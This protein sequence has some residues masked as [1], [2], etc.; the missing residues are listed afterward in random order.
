MVWP[1]LNNISAWCLSTIVALCFLVCGVSKGQ[2]IHENTE[3]KISA[4]GSQSEELRLTVANNMLL[5]QRNMGGWPKHVNNVKLDYTRILTVAEVAGIQND[6][7]RN[8]ATIDNGSTVK[9][10]RFLA[11]QYKLTGNKV[12]LQAVEKG[13]NYL[14]KA[15]YAN[16][17]WP[18]YYPDLSLYRHQITYNDHAMVNVLNLLY[19]VNTKCNDLESVD[20]SFIS[21]TKK[22][23]IKGIDCILKTQ[24]KVNGKLTVWCA[25]HD[26]KTLK[27]ANART[28]ELASLS[29]MESVGILYF[30]IRQKNPSE[31]IERAV[32][33]GASW[34]D[35][36]KIGG[37]KYTNINDPKQPNGWDRALVP[38]ND[39]NVWAR[40]Y[41]VETFEPFFCGRDGIKK[42]VL[43]QIEHERRMGYAWYGT[44][45]ERFLKLDYP[46]WLKSNNVKVNY[47]RS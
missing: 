6:A 43:N 19:D 12:Y 17:G 39:S 26:E 4:S 28:F 25:Q 24:V 30:L 27:P 33:A 10:I 37:Y 47:V 35:K 16:G 41:E 3:V 23:V 1:R 38:A 2:Y 14:L 44:W 22:A 15:Q 34:L 45:P 5:Y 20:Q 46:G 42:R 29:G 31:E 36:V 32:V 21:K 11:R 18:Q 40:F 13:L 8:D 9:E 7:F